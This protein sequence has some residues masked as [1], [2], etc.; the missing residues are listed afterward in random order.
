MEA[1]SLP[2]LKIN[3][4]ELQ[5]LQ[6]LSEG[7]SSPLKGFMREQEYLQALHFNCVLNEDGVTR[8]NQ[9]VPIVLS[10]TEEDKKRLEDVSA[11][12]LIYEGN[13]VAILR[14]PDFY[15]QR[16]EERCSR[17]FGTTNLGHPYVKVRSQI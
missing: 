16:K 5:W 13:P 7:W 2:S 10:L 17:Q 11:M 15:F 6:I 12:T 9:S 3:T 4:V 1:K 8:H 14:N